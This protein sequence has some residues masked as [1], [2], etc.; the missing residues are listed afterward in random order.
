LTYLRARYYDPTTGQFLIVDPAIAATVSPYQYVS[1]NPLNAADPSGLRPIDPGPP[2][3]C[4]NGRGIP[5]PQGC[6]YEGQANP[7][8]DNQQGPTLGDVANIVGVLNL[9]DGEGEI[10][11]VCEEVGSKIAA[12]IAEQTVQDVLKSKLGSIT[13]ASL[14]KGSPSWDDIRNMSMDESKSRE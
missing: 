1:G 11:F 8:Y 4:D 6:Y 12:D 10:Q 2:A 7:Q 3:P 9:E 14:P 13:R 5:G